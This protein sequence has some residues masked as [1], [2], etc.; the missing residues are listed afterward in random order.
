M[1]MDESTS[2]KP[3]RILTQQAFDQL[4]AGL[5]TDRERAGAEY[6]LLRRKLVRFFECRGSLFPE[7]HTDETIN[8]VA[9]KLAEGEILRNPSSYFY[10][11]AR[12]VVVESLRRQANEQA[13]LEHPSSP[14]V[15]TQSRESDRL[16]CLRQCMEQLP[17]ESRELLVLY[18]EGEKAVK[19]ESR[20]KL[21]ERL[22][23]PLNAVRIR[24]CRLRKALGTCVDKCLQQQ[25]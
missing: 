18:Y 19:I 25:N 2:P 5:A 11:V 12:W 13:L 6:E 4:L 3:E 16:S 21:A 1:I 24:A 14:P 15:P 8:R 20:R 22:R 17:P 7:D 23:T 9:R 10:G